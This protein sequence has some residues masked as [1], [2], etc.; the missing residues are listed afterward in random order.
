MSKRGRNSLNL[1]TLDGKQTKVDKQ[2]RGKWRRGGTGAGDEGNDGVC[3][4]N[5]N[6]QFVL[7]CV[8]RLQGVIMNAA[9]DLIVS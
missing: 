1:F 4:V 9:A 3:F 5:D 7:D 2:K 8:K 6:K